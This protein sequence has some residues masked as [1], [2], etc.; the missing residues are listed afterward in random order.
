MFQR[1]AHPTWEQS[2]LPSSPCLQPP[3]SPAAPPALL[4]GW[5]E[6]LSTEILRL[7]N[8]HISLFIFLAV[9]AL[10]SSSRSCVTSPATAA[11]GQEQLCWC[12]GTAEERPRSPSRSKPQ[13]PA[14]PSQ[15]NCH[16]DHKKSC[17]LRQLLKVLEQHTSCFHY[18]IKRTET[19]KTHRQNRTTPSSTALN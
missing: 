19:Q 14:S 9:L 2:H 16:M 7:K 1:D 18:D 11:Q 17:L 4:C 12:W 15:Q 3:A 8:N 13:V 5:P 6:D 10:W